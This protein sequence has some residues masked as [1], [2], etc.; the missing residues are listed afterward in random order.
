MLHDLRSN[1]RQMLTG[2]QLI[3]LRVIM[4][5]LLQMP[6]GGQLKKL[7]IVMRRLQQMPTDELLRTC[8]DAQNATNASWR[9]V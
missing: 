3:E 8:N 2:K 9:V 5:K 1:V 7:C 6:A 4:R